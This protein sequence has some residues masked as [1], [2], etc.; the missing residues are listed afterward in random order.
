MTIRPAAP[1]DLASVRDCTARAYEGYVPL[2]GRRPQPMT[3]DFAADIARGRIWVAETDGAVAGAITCLARGAAMFV[4]SVAV[5]PERQ[6]RGL[7]RSLLGF[8]ETRAR[9]AG[10]G[11]MELY[12][13]AR[14]TGNL[15]FYPRLGYRETSRKVED[16]FE[17]VYF[18]KPLGPAEEVGR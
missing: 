18:D 16:G 5:L 9:D 11:R 8:A 1:D 3:A 17:R 12:T 4:E 14:M 13:N 6:G 2:L 15:A 10:L 7:G